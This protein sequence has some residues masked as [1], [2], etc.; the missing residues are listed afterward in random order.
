MISTKALTPGL[1]REV[2]RD[3]MWALT[4]R[5]LYRLLLVQRGWSGAQYQRHVGDLLLA[6]LANG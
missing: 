6:A 2:A 5:D 1:K 3:I 4:S